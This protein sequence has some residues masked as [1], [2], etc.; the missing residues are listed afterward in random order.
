MTDLSSV[1]GRPAP[2]PAALLLDATEDAAS[3]LL[4]LAGLFAAPPEEGTFLSLRR[5]AAADLL[6]RLADG[7][8]LAAPI[9]AFRA[10]IETPED[11]AMLARR[12][13]PVFGLLF[14]GLGGPSTVAPYESVHT[15]GGR[16]WQAPAGEMER[17]LAAHDLSAG[18]EREPADHL[19]IETAFLARLVAIGHPDREDL[20]R[21]LGAW[22]P[23]FA[24]DLA[25]ADGTGV[26][27]AAARLLVAAI[28][29]ASD[30]STP[31]NEPR[32]A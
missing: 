9:A 5:G 20:A 7:A 21:R 19:S 11:E 31:R 24:D 18:L 29:H 27:A 32:K 26:F 1:R 10:T 23:T 22:V 17:L 6:T 16:M 28:E 15:C 13:A 4:L 2:A 8:T 14:L 30:A 25:H 12:L 3:L